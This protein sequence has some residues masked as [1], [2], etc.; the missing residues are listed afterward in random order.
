M[1][2]YKVLKQ[3]KTSLA[4]LGTLKTAHGVVNTPVFMP[5]GT[6]GA[7]KAIS[8]DDLRALGAEIIL[9]NTYHLYLRPGEKLIKKM[10]GLQAF[11]LWNGPILTDSGGY[12]VFSLG[13]KYNSNLRIDP[14]APNTDNNSLVKITEKGVIFKSHLDGSKHFFTPEKVIDIQLALG[15]DIIMVLD[16]CTEYPA[17]YKRAKEAM[18]LTHRWAKRSIMHFQKKM[19]KFQ[20]ANSKL[21]INSKIL[22]SKQY[23]KRPLLFGIAQGSTYRD[24]R[25][26]SA[27]YISS[28]G[29]DGIAV[30]GVSVGEGKTNMKQVIK[31]VSKYLPKDKPHYLMGVGE[32]DDLIYAIKYGFDMFDCVLPTRLARHGVIWV[33]KKSKINPPTGGQKSKLLNN[34]TKI[35]LRKSVYRTDKKTI[36][37]YCGCYTCKNKFSRS[38]LQHLIKEKEMLG[39][40][41]LSIHNLHQIV[42]LLKDIRL[43]IN[44]NQI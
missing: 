17:T 33:Q 9:G 37:K 13:H 15:S 1:S 38:Y 42:N 11:N 39:A 35:N 21:Q 14:N 44:D 30:G 36:D 28:L 40:R 31:W 41:L 4:R 24:L 19:Q 5:V 3:S 16:V 29:F 22:N 2:N 20:M 10:G 18:E 26:E 7:V 12:Q 6:V 27:K 34:F 43:S 32:P 25:I 23:I 8:P